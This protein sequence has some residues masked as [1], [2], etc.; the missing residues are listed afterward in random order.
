[1]PSNNSYLLFTFA[2]NRMALRISDICATSFQIKQ[3]H[4]DALWIK[5]LLQFPFIHI[6]RMSWH[7]ETEQFALHCRRENPA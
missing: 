2:F 4:E 7:Y 5:R 6:V 1:M 3:S